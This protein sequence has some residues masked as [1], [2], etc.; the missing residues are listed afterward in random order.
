MR[1]KKL[2]ALLNVICHIK[3]FVYGCQ[4][5]LDSGV[6][7]DYLVH[8]VKAVPSVLTSLNEDMQ[9]NN[10]L[11]MADSGSLEGSDT[12]MK[13]E[14]KALLRAVDDLRDELSNACAVVETDPKDLLFNADESV[15]ALGAKWHIIVG[16]LYLVAGRCHR[17]EF[18]L[19][20]LI[21]YQF[22]FNT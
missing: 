20:R 8:L 2:L 13:S 9:H 16:R 4:L 11:I 19:N 14:L 1:K 21:N 10:D 15:T 18:V 17:V 7:A 6:P 22:P 5:I 12:T 3:T